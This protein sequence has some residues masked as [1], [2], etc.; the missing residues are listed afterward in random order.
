MVQGMYNSMILVSNFSP[1]IDSGNSD[2]A[3]C[4]SVGL[5]TLTPCSFNEYNEL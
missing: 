4:V 5:T 1:Q 2:S 3:V